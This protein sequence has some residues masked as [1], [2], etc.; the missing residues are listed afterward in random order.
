[1][2][3]VL[4]K[5]PSAAA[6][7]V[8]ENLL[9]S[10]SAFQLAA[11]SDIE[12]PPDVLLA[13]FNTLADPGAREAL[14]WANSGGPVVLLLRNPSDEVIGEALRAGV[15]AVLGSSADGPK[16]AAAIEAAA[17]GLIV[18]D[19]VRTDAFSR[20]PTT[21][22]G[23]VSGRPVE[24]LTSREVEV[25]QLL[26]SGLGN[27]EIA[28]RLEISEHTAKFHVASILGKLGAGS[29]TEAVTIGIRLGVIM[30]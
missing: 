28:V 25:L 2:I 12:Y 5:A 30:V 11:D 13:E 6:R 29:R 4:I 18:L 15:K 20:L 7:A 8:L 27:K 1:M 14:E 23:T 9:E 26:A 21:A 19:A 24:S 17:A 16:I 10:H 22:A 3:R